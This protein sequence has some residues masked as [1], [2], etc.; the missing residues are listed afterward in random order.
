MNDSKRKRRPPAKVTNAE[1]VLAGNYV[2]EWFGH[3]V[4]PTVSTNPNMIIDQSNARCPFLSQATAEERTCI[5]SAASKGVCTINSVGNGKRQDWLVCPYRAV[6][7]SLLESCIRRLFSVSDGVTVSVFPAPTLQKSDIR[8]QVI[9]NLSLGNP[10]FVF[11]QDKLGGEISISPTDRS[12]EFS[13]D[14]TIVQITNDQEKIDVG[15]YG[16][17]EVQTMDF[18]GTYRHAVKNLEDALRLHKDEFPK[19]LQEHTHWLSEEIEGPNIA[20]VFKRT[21]YQMMFKFQLGIDKNCA[22]CVLAIPNSVWD[23]WQRHLGKPDLRLREDG[24]FVLRKPLGLEDSEGQIKEVREGYVPPDEDSEQLTTIIDR[25]LAWIYVFDIDS[26]S[27][28][29]PNPIVID[30]VI[31]T[32]AASFSYFALQISPEAAINSSAISLPLTLRRRLAS[33]WDVFI[34]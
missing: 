29:S 7:P 13:F 2:S 20:N 34:T 23:S 12:P 14:I 31:A 27:Q 5:K 15:R 24:L 30:R 8:E 19:A 28:M 21:F 25:A 9:T 16:I 6:E 22:G 3:R 4:Y 1:Q 33:W 18:H 10:V 11:F 32:D 26:S 17:L